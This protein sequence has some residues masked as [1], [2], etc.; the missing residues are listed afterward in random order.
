MTRKTHPKKH[1]KNRSEDTAPD[2][3]ANCP[4]D[5]IVI[6]AGPVGAVQALLLAND[7]FSVAVIDH[8][9]PKTAQSAAFDGRTTALSHGATQILK[10]A[11][12]WQKLSKNAEPILD[13][14]II[15]S[16]SPRVLRFDRKSAGG[17][18]MGHIVLNLDLRKILYAALMA[19]KNIRAF[20]PQTIESIKSD[21]GAVS[22]ELK[23]AKK[24][25]GTIRA[26]IL[27]AADG[28]RSAVR[29][30]FGIASRRH[31]YGHYAV[32]ATLSHQKPHRNIAYEC[33]YPEGPLAILP[34]QK[35][36]GKHCSSLVWSM[37]ADA[38]KTLAEMDDAEFCQFLRE[39]FGA[40]LGD[41]ACIGA[42]QIFP[43]TLNIAKQFYANRIALIGDAAHGIHPI[44]G[45]GLNLGLRDCAS[46]AG[47][48]RQKRDLGLDPGSQTAL[49]E[50]DKSRAFDVTSMIAATHGLNWLF[51]Q[52]HAGARILRGAGLR[53]VGAI[54][55]LKSA[56]IKR[57]MGDF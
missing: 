36:R 22:V 14:D 32:V 20:M 27:I 7:G 37:R 15:D 47:I 13:I 40:R 46:L 9:D 34:M 28:R 26:P 4:V 5:C 8:L 45:Q 56:F 30:Q 19:H 41:F 1:K 42:R 3:I 44:A 53:I 23:S 57:A 18:A 24:D 17:R 55:Q 2:G 35:I 10:D 11:G 16:A 50:Y 29:E 38:A 51:A 49:R 6:G 12:V 39:R 33:F 25:A 21:A 54:P 48:L 52:N 43:I 31:N